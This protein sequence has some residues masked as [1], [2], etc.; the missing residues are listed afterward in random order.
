MNI[1][2][3]MA[4]EKHISLENL[5]ITVSGDIDPSRAFGMDSKNRAGFTQ[6]SVQVEMVPRLSEGKLQEFCRELQERCP[7][8]DT[9]GNRTPLQIN[10]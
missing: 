9:V 3:I 7:L 2:R 10:L 1:A 5:T 4:L 6:M 8:C